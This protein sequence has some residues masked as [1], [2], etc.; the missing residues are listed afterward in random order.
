MQNISQELRDAIWSLP[1]AGRI[2]LL[3]LS[4][5]DRRARRL[6]PSWA[7]SIFQRV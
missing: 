6:M 4:V 7:S 2:A 5:I 3:T 1:A